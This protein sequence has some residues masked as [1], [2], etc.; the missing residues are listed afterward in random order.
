MC[1]RGSAPTEGSIIAETYIAS[2][3]SFPPFSFSLSLTFSFFFFFSF[4]NTH[5]AFPHVCERKT[6]KKGIAQCHSRFTHDSLQAN[7]QV[8]NESKKEAALTR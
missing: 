4:L 3:P 5:V 6:V 1:I 2:L 7:E 8:L